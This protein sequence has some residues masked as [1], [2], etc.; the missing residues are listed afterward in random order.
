MVFMLP[1][2]ARMLWGLDNHGDAVSKTVNLW[3]ACQLSAD[4][5]A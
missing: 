1:A 4:R 3:A 2:I 5:D